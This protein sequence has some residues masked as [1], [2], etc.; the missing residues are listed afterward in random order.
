[1]V[2]VNRIQKAVYIDKKNEDISTSNES[3]EVFSH[4]QPVHFLPNSTWLIHYSALP[5]LCVEG[6]KDIERELDRVG[7]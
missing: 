1:M 6:E 7:G 4:N 2:A 5:Y 3:P